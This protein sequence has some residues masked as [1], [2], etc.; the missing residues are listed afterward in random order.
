MP[1]TA[2]GLTVLILAF[3][4]GAAFSG[5]VFYA[6]YSFRKT[7]AENEIKKFTEGFD[8]RFGTAT[9]TIQAESANAKAEI[10]KELEPLRKIRAEGETL[11]EL[12]KKVAPSVWFVSTLDEAG[13]PSVGSAFVVA[14]DGDQTLLL[15]SYT[16]VRAATKQPGP[17]VEVRK[18]D[19][20]VRATLHT[21]QEERDLALLIINRGNVPKLEFGP[22][23]DLK[24]GERVFAVSGLGGAG[25]A[26]TQGFVADVSA[27]GI[28]HD[29]SIGPSFQGGPLV[30]SEG[31]VLAIA[32][33]T[34]NGGLNFV[35]DDVYFGIPIRAA[36]DKV[37]RCPS[38]TVSGAGDRR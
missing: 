9:K 12:V 37:V 15:T 28:Q 35:T 17:P 11:E 10:Q 14:S 22:K 4:V 19:Q 29:A 36:C 30:N 23:E 38:G 18:G 27:N 8:E 32:S 31:K 34:Y 1:R 16:T 3:S 5:T 25:G 20:R 24:V 2:L 13:G 7:E 26:V 6:Y 21:W 33:R